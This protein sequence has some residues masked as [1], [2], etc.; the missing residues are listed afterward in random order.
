[1][2]QLVE[3]DQRNLRALPV[4]NRGFELQVGELDLA[5]ARPAPLAHP[6]MRG[7]AE[8]GIEIEALIPQSSGIGDL[9]HGAAE[10]DGGEI[11]NP[12]DM[13]QRLQD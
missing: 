8:P 7:A 1:M 10:E 9:G 13:A 2:R 12:A 3:A 6:Q 11:G 4:V 5:T